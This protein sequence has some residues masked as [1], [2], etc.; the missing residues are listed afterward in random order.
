MTT[1]HLPMAGGHPQEFGGTL[2]TDAWWIAPAIT[3]IVFTSF[4]AYGT[5]AAFQGN[6]Y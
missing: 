3:L 5:W 6:H 2:R 4:L 1:R